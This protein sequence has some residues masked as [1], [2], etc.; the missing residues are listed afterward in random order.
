[1]PVCAGFFVFSFTGQANMSTFPHS[2]TI[3]YGSFEIVEFAN[4]AKGQAK[5][6]DGTIVDLTRISV[7]NQ[8]A[9]KEVSITISTSD[10]LAMH[11]IH[12][13]SECED[14]VWLVASPSWSKGKDVVRSCGRPEIVESEML[15]SIPPRDE[16][17]AY[18]AEYR[19]LT[20]GEVFTVR[21]SGMMVP[22]EN[23]HNHTWRNP[24]ARFDI[25]MERP[26]DADDEPVP[27]CRTFRISLPPAICDGEQINLDCIMFNISREDLDQFT[28]PEGVR[29]QR[30]PCGGSKSVLRDEQLAMRVSVRMDLAWER[31]VSLLQECGVLA[32]GSDFD[33]KRIEFG[34]SS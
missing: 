9:A 10:G 33:V 14:L 6:A 23:Y 11:H 12:A 7:I 1:M 5:T 29:V 8:D 13:P 2:N 34:G 4:S 15:M 21:P 31:M 17:D 18:G 26:D 3:T 28:P 32:E 30:F 16:Y 22:F 25:E 24:I 20:P 19:I 27:T